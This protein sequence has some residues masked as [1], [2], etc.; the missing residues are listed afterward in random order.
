MLGSTLL[1]DSYNG[2]ITN[3]INTTCAV[4]FVTRS[5]SINA[6]MGRPSFFSLSDCK[7]FDI[8]FMGKILKVC[9]LNSI[10]LLKNAYVKYKNKQD[11]I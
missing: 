8:H 1:N 2:R 11:N 3:R 6:A 7:H 5:L 4:G 10:Y 9:I